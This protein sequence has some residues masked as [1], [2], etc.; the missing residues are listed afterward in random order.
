MQLNET[1]YRRE[2]L[3]NT[4]EASER[5]LKKVLLLGAW[6][7]HLPSVLGWRR[8]DP[9]HRVIILHDLIVHL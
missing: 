9:A 7:V 8:I 3:L 4:R 6:C 5:L 1:E 2:L